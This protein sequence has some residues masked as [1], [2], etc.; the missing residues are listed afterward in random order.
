M[1]DEAPR[2]PGGIA[3][4]IRSAPCRSIRNPVDNPPAFTYTV[5]YMNA[6]DLITFD[7]AASRLGISESDLEELID[8]GELH[9]QPSCGDVYLDNDEVAALAVERRPTTNDQRPTRKLNYVDW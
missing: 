9:T 6:R 5:V 1:R 2:F 4:P 7:K 3:G 8:S